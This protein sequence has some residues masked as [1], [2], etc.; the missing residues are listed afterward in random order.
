MSA[1]QGNGF[2]FWQKL[3]WRRWPWP[4]T[5]LVAVLAVML[6]FIAHETL[7]PPASVARP[8]DARV[9]QRELPQPAGATDFRQ[10]V[11]ADSDSH[12]VAGN[13]R[14]EPRGR[15]SPVS[16]EVPGLVHAILV[17]EGQQVAQGTPLV[18]L[19]NAVEEAAAAAARAELESE[20]ANLQRILAGARPMERTAAEADARAAH[21]KAAFSDDTLRRL[22]PL[23]R[24][25]AATP[26]EIE[27][28]R[29]E[30]DFDRASAA[31]ADERAHLLESG[32][33]H[34]DIQV[35]RARAEAAAARYAQAQAALAERTV[36][37]PLAGTVLSIPAQA[38]EYFTPQ[39]SAP[40]VILGDLGRLRVR[41]EVDERQIARVH[42][43]ARAW[44]TADA[45][46]TQRFPG[47]VVDVGHRM[48][49][50]KIQTDLPTDRVDTDVL[51]VLID[52]DEPG[53]L[54]PGLRVTAYVEAA[55]TG[56]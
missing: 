1:E 53:P 34:E 30:A 45:F 27:K 21:A 7:R 43:G 55:Q 35:A 18:Q 2:T 10:P 12:L 31:A 26:Q 48:G 6:G 8:R 19:D 28:A 54:L 5:V 25:G 23:G 32:S 22:E 16:A 37:A 14:V 56:A 42:L 17:R 20:R 24:T 38:G 40:L 51:E 41:M 9:A 47:R 49:R 52:L 39:S 4:R 36:L 50:K 44:V 29:R 13:G 3:P 11:P 46:G 33:R 15:E